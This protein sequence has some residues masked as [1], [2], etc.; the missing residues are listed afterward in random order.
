MSANPLPKEL[1]VELWIESQGEDALVL[2]AIWSH[3]QR[4]VGRASSVL[5]A[6]CEA[7]DAHGV[8]IHA[9]V[10]PLHYADHKGY[11]SADSARLH[12]LDDAAP[13]ACHLEAWYA[14]FGFTRKWGSDSRNPDI[15]RLCAGP[16]NLE[17]VGLF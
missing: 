7:A 1:Q 13:D 14:K 15:M 3:G 10:H 16:A 4:G 6:L 5:R 12:A 2:E 11:F 17:A 9:Y 8:N